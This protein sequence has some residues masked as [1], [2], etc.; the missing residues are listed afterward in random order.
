MISI[1]C[2]LLGLVRTTKT[3]ANPLV[4]LETAAVTGKWTNNGNSRAFY[5]IRYGTPPTGDLRFR[6]PLPHT[7]Q[8]AVNATMQ[9][10]RCHQAVT[11]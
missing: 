8:G 1:I 6:P 10:A 9:G 11:H 7:L 5:G 3:E 4:N 2:I